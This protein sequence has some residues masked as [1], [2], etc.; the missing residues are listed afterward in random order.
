MAAAFRMAVKLGIAQRSCENRLR[1][2]LHKCGLPVAFKEISPKKI[3]EVHFHDKKFS[4]GRSRFVLPLDIGKVKVVEDIPPE[5]VEE[6]I[7]ECM[8]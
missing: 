5:V 1:N 4:S 6:A 7:T 3:Y 2:I 8:G